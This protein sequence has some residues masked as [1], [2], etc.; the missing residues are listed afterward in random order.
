MIYTFPHDHAECP[1]SKPAVNCSPAPCEVIKCPAHP[2]AKCVNSI[3]GDCKAK[4][5]EPG[6]NEV[7]DTCRCPPGVKLMHCSDDPC[8]F[9]TCPAYPDATCMADY[10]GGC[11]AIFFQ[12]RNEI[13]KNCHNP[14]PPHKPLAKCIVD[15]CKVIKCHSHP[16]AICKANYCGGCNAIFFEKG[17]E[18]TGRCGMLY[19]TYIVLTT[20]MNNES[21]DYN[22]SRKNKN[23]PQ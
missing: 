6:G 3:C 22:D 17:V 1:S 10:C 15:P 14:C 8:L 18:V 16:D 12:G 21:R 13:T 20:S 7:T 5:M 19:Y 2:N 4:F 11:N 9:T 23:V